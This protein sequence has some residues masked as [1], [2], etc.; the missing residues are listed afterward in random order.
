VIR[1]VRPQEPEPLRR[2]RPQKLE[3]ART[4][5]GCE[6]KIKFS[7][8]GDDGV[9]ESLFQG[10]HRKCAYCEKWEEQSKYREAE[11]YRPKSYY[12][13][14]AW[15]WENLLFACMDCNR[16]YKKEQFPLVDETKRL[17]A[18]EVAPGGEQP[19]LIDPY[20]PSIEPTSEI[21]F[22]RE[23]VQRKERWVPYGLTERGRETIRICGL[24]RPSLL[25]AYELHVRDDV[26]VKVGR[27]LSVV[28]TNDPQ[29]IVKAWGTLTRGLFGSFR[30]FQALSRDALRV[31]VPAELRSRYQ[32]AL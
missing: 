22:R 9:K 16:E 10:Q 8:Y 32:L 18:E 31:L 7:G 2:K 1:L 11:H 24:E 3:D 5:L 19:L 21:E 13:W 28:E 25:T 27:F 17:V 4:A 6:K 26:R 20:D 14:L 12:W 23:L 29:L 15:T 30:P